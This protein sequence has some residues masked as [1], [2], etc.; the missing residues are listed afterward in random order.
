M[1]LGEDGLTWEVV[2]NKAKD[3]EPIRVTRHQPKL[4][5]VMPNYDDEFEVKEQDFKSSDKQDNINVV[6]VRRENN[7]NVDVIRSFIFCLLL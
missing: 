4:A 1:V 2:G 7:L 6:E 3:N 5:T